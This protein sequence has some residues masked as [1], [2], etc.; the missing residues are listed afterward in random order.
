M[1][2]SQ[3]AILRKYGI[4][5]VKRRGQNF[6]VDGNLAR[7][8]AADTLAIG[9]NVLEL[10]AGGG[11]LTVHLLAAA[12]RVACVEVDRN[13]C[14]LLRSEFGAREEFRLIE[15]DLAKLDW[16]GAL[17]EAGARPVVAGNLPYVLT[18]KV[19]FALADLRESIS[20]AVFM[21][22]K[23]VAERLAASPGGRDYGILA[24]VLGSVFEVKVMRAV[25]ASVFWPKP[26]VESAIIRLIPRGSWSRSEFENFTQVVKTLFG[27]RRKKLRTQLRGHYSL[28]PEAVEELAA[29]VGVDPDSRP[30]QIDPEGFR[31]L[32]GALIRKDDG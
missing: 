17:A 4:R 21:V 29:R 8:I 11:A 3:H 26:E 15:G 10:G 19:L 25:P 18:S 32:A 20:G 6:L 9:D 12:A 31:H 22:Q 24:V 5:P 16:A 30:E 27:Q 2:E 23:E 7:A 28:S 1:S 14:E 13:L